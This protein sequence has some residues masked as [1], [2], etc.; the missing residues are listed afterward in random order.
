MNDQA[1]DRYIT[2]LGLDCDRNADR[3][4]E[5]LQTR[6]KA[7]SSRWVAY[8]RQKLDENHRSGMDN[9]YFVG[10]QVNAQQS[11]FE[12]EADEE[13]LALLWHLEHNCC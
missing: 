11:Y 8:F 4:I 3:M 10:S 1:P 9:L 13:A 7:G 2:F 5:M 6:M 12:E